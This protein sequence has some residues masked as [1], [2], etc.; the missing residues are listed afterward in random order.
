MAGF[1]VK[2]STN[3]GPQAVDAMEL[4]GKIDNAPIGNIGDDA[5]RPEQE[6]RVR[7]ATEIIRIGPV[8]PHVA[9]VLIEHAPV[10]VKP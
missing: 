6:M 2:A 5:K 9:N 7:D 10:R 8:P 1:E 4:G 3:G